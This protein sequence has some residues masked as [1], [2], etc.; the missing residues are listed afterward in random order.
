MCFSPLVASSGDTW[1][2]ASFSLPTAVNRTML[3]LF[4]SLP[5]TK[6]VEQ[7]LSVLHQRLSSPS[8]FLPS[9][10]QHRGGGI[11][12][13]AK[14]I[15]HEVAFS[16]QKN[17]V[18]GHQKLKPVESRHT[19]IRPLRLMGNMRKSSLWTL[20]LRLV[21]EALLPHRVHPVYSFPLSLSARR[22]I[23]FRTRAPPLR[24]LMFPPFLTVSP[25]G[26]N[27]HVPVSSSHTVSTGLIQLIK[28]V[29]VNPVTHPGPLCIPQL[30]YSLAYCLRLTVCVW[31]FFGGGGGCV[32]RF[33][34]CTRAHT[35]VFH[36]VFFIVSFCY[37][38][39]A[40][41]R[42]Y[43]L[44]FISCLLQPIDEGSLREWAVL[45]Q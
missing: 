36:C 35:A 20:L 9:S 27:S 19:F 1:D 10:K 21:K 28:V 45:L 8:S 34:Y 17:T 18:V 40:R 39:L 31:F 12:R 41:W 4:S 14:R 30:I 22:V 16:T 11:L 6:W 23:W 5:R 38:L 42:C 37:G 33:V 3:L 29:A 7:R 44:D 43:G 32:I 2:P 26:V 15:N 24:G 13:R 25:L